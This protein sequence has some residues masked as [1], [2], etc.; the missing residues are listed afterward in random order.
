MET[1]QAKEGGIQMKI[2]GQ[3]HE[4]APDMGFPSMVDSMAKGTY[5]S[6]E[7]ILTYLRNGK[8]HMVTA[9]KVVDALTKAQTKID[10]VFMNDGSYAWTS[11]IIYYVDRYNLQLPDEFVNH[12]LKK[13]K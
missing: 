4:L 6:K 3:Y 9:S 12:I 5:A 13:S 11:A 10:L 1:V 2:I 7:A 8:V